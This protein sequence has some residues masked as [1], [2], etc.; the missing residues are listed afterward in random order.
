MISVST[1]ETIILILVFTGVST[2][3]LR[4]SYPPAIPIEKYASSLSPECLAPEIKRF[5]GRIPSDTKPPVGTTPTS[6]DSTVTSQSS[7]RRD[8]NHNIV[9]A[10]QPININ[11]APSLPISGMPASTLPGN[12]N[13]I[14][15]P[16]MTRTATGEIAVVLPPH[17]LKQAAASQPNSTGGLILPIYTLQQA[18]A[19]QGTDIKS[20]VS[21]QQGAVPHQ[22][23]VMISINMPTLQQSQCSAFTSL[24]SSSSSSSTTSSIQSSQ[25]SPVSPVW[26]PW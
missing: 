4:D 9:A 15:Q 5:F 25:Q 1:F 16:M 24:P 19:Q 20:A 21:P 22:Q 8:S 26:R 17:L 2:P 23:P 6:P 11:T 7:I 10:P 14:T 13:T 3:S 18:P 12:V